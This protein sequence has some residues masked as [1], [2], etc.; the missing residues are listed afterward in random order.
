[1][2]PRGRGSASSSS[3][4][5]DR[6]PAAPKGA[7]AAEAGFSAPL[8]DF[9]AYLRIECGLAPASIAAYGRDL[10][11]L[12]AFLADEGVRTPREVK[13]AHLAEHVRFLSRERGLDPAST[14]RHV[15]TVRVFFRFLHAVRA[16][17]DDPARLLERPT[18]WRKI[19]DTI[20]PS[21]MR[22]LVDAPTPDHGE[23]WV[24]DRAILELMYAAG[25]RASEVGSVRLNQWHPVLSSMHVVG[26][27]S[28]QRIV[29]VGV[30]AAQAIARWLEELRPQLVG[31]DETRADHR[32]FVSNRGKPLERVA[33]WGLVTKYAAVAGIHGVHPHVLRHSFAT[34]LLRGGCDLRTVQEFLGHTSVVTTQIYTHVDKSKLRETVSRCH[35]RFDR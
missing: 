17:P 23:L 32:L 24:R 33:V 13:P 3:P 35:P 4:S 10:D 18:K 14:V 11:D 31:A 2:K 27:G 34:D 12:V 29:P 8:R 30:P 9:I 6:A 21:Q 20:S 15:S 28:K 7:A 22:R 19:P 5:D 16:I 25:L 1:M 26:K